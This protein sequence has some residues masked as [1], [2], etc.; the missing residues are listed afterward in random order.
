MMLNFRMSVLQMGNRCLQILRKL[1][2]AT[3]RSR[4]KAGIQPN[5]NSSEANNYRN[6]HWA[7]M[8]SQASE[9]KTKG[10]QLFFTSNQQANQSHRV[11]F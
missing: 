8:W 5:L 7:L 6:S 10:S 1:N 2:T 11:V 4:G 9:P 3:Q